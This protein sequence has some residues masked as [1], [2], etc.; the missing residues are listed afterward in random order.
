MRPAS[1]DA[2]GGVDKKM[3]DYHDHKRMYKKMGKEEG[4]H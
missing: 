3:V 2:V 4:Q 1:Y